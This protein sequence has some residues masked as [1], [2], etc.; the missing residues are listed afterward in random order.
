MASIFVYSNL[1]HNSWLCVEG[2]IFS[3]KIFIYHSN[4]KNL[5]P[6]F[7]LYI[8]NC[9]IIQGYHNY[10]FF[11]RNFL[12]SS[13]IGHTLPFFLKPWLLKIWFSIFLL[14]SLSFVFL[15][16]LL[17]MQMAVG[18]SN[19]ARWH[20]HSHYYKLWSKQRRFGVFR[21]TQAS[22]NSKC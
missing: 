18:L 6:H 10:N 15:R 14:A 20:K 19:L 16:Y 4:K 1:L 7:K 2:V 8:K 5:Y 17:P 13:F 11:Q 9:F 3:N 12:A 22:G 21:I